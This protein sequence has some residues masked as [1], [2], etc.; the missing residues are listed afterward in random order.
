M[1]PRESSG[2]W[3]ASS[4]RPT[5]EP[6]QV[7]CCSR[8]GNHR[9]DKTDPLP[10]MPRLHPRPR[11]WSGTCGTRGR[12]RGWPRGGGATPRTHRSRST[13]CTWIVEA[14]SGRDS[15]MPTTVTWRRRWSSTLQRRALRTSNSCLSWSIHSTDH[16]DI[17]R[18][19]T[20]PRPAATGRPQD[21]MYLIDYLHQHGI[22]VIL[23]WVL[24]IS[25]PTSMVLGYFDGTHLYEH[26]DPRQGWHTRLELAT[27]SIMDARKSASSCSTAHYSGW[28]S[29]RRRAARRC[30]GVDAVPRLLA[31]E[32]GWIPNR[33]GGGRT[34]RRSTSCAS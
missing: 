25:R 12:R 11:R 2:I 16:G 31:K 24:R 28:T 20:S 33:Y 10:S 19:A 7:F 32:G 4:P 17:N 13:K 6:L 22:G 29:P 9:V 23:D 34:S 21:L 14:L 27:C 1:T 26:A 3:E 18:P 30:G 15:N 8:H 5:G